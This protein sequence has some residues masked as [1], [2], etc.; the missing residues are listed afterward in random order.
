[1]RRSAIAAAVGL[2]ALST[3][4][5]AFLSC[6]AATARQPRDAAME[7]PPAAA[8]SACLA[9]ADELPR[10]PTGALPCELIPPGLTLDR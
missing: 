2:L 9:R 6:D 7:Q 3:T 1:M 8:L 4:A 10:P 5:G